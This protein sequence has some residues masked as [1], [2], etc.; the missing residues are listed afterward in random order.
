MSVLADFRI[1]NV[2]YANPKHDLIAV[3]YGNKEETDDSKMRQYYIPIDNPNNSD[4]KHIHDL[5]YS[6]EDIYNNTVEWN[7]KLSVGFQQMIAQHAR[8]DIK[9]I[10][11]ES[12]EKIEKLR[13]NTYTSGKILLEALLKADANAVREAKVTAFEMNIIKDADTAIKMKLRSAA[14]ISEIATIIDGLSNS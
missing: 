13:E 11:K 1:I 2:V 5:G 3:F 7:Q 12:K 10:E 4:L 8:E 9:R 14:T 6:F